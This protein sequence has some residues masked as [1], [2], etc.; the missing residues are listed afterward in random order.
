M[1][2]YTFTPPDEFAIGFGATESIASQ[3]LLKAYPNALNRVGDVFEVVP[4]RGYVSV[5]DIPTLKEVT[6]RP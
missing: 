4:N 5:D 6:F 3:E 1:P 2:L